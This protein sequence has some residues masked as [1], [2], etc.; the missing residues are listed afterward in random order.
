M[1]SG[2]ARPRVVVL[3]GP[4]VALAACT[5]NVSIGDEASDAGTSRYDAPVKNLDAGGRAGPDAT[6]P[7]DARPPS[8]DAAD[9]GHSDAPVQKSDAAVPAKCPPA[10]PAVGSQ[11][12]DVGLEC[13]YGTSSNVDC[14]TI[15]RCTSTG[16]RQITAGTAC[17]MGT[18]PAQYSN[19]TVGMSCTPAG[20]VCAYSEGTCT[21]SSPSA[22]VKPDGGDPSTAARWSCVAEQPNCPTPRP[23]LGT[24]CVA[25][26][27]TCDYGSCTG[28]VALACTNG[29]WEE[30]L[31]ACPTSTSSGSGSATPGSGT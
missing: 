16:W 28:G 12:T 5:W 10:E 19:I 17:V 21:C 22:A 13:E 15:T 30:A 9:A 14:N 24:P 6:S 29:L 20:E 11:C 8:R 7:G 1:T 27:A 3:W 2:V 31:T 25:T 18:C 23:K 26:S 4:F